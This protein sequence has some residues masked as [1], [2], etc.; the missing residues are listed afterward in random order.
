MSKIQRV[1]VPGLPT[2]VSHYCHVTRA[3][4]H[5][6]VAGVVGQAPDGSGIGLALVKKTIERF[7]GEIQVI[8]DP[9]RTRG[10]TFRVTWPKVI[11]P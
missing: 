9:A 1:I 7:G 10:T 2:P 8:S 3:G 11:A 6:W 4:P 5:V